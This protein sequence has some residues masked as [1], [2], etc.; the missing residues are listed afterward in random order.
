[1]LTRAMHAFRRSGYAGLSVRDLERATGLS[2]G[3]LYH[4]YGGKRG[5]FD[6]AFEYYNVSVLRARLN[7][8]APAGSGI[9]GLRELIRSLLHE[10]DGER[11]GCL[12]TNS[13][14]EFGPGPPHPG[15]SR[16]FGLLEQTFTARLEEIGGLAKP[17]RAAA[18][19]RLL[20][21]YQGLL[22]L[23]RGGYDLDACERMIEQEFNDLSK[24]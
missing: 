15:V 8:Y 20:V 21:L 1:M 12:I 7:R 19:T 13:A 16:A 10:P 17:A 18:A 22:V 3:S 5:L 4:A 6:A 9:E 14:I 11:L 2:G 24:G 23:V